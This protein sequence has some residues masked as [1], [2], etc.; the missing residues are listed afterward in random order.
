ML[1]VA[2][3]EVIFKP[4][5]EGAVLFHA[6]REIYFGLNPVGA[7]VWELLPPACQD[8]DQLCDKLEEEYADADAATIRGDVNELLGELASHELVLERAEHGSI[9]EASSSAA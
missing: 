8:F 1:P 2:N 7:R 6:S 5:S 4:L 3:Q 9:N